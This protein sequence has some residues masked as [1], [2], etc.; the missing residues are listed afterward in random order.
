[1]FDYETKQDTCASESS[2]TQNTREDEDTFLEKRMI[3]LKK[4][5]HKTKSAQQ[6]LPHKRLGYLRIKE[7]EGNA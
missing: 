5:K 1:M 2:S 4:K 3:S 7:S 6:K